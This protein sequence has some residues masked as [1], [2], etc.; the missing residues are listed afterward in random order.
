MMVPRLKLLASD[1]LRD[2]GVIFV[3]IDDNEA[4]HLRCLMDEV[5][6]EENVRWDGRLEER[7]R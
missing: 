3:S 2:D 5:F 1:L 4:H 6:G 7:Y